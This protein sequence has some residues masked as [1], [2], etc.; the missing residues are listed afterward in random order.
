MDTGLKVKENKTTIIGYIVRTK[1]TGL[2]ALCK[3]V[4]MKHFISANIYFEPSLNI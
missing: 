1:K 3:N 4:H 2:R